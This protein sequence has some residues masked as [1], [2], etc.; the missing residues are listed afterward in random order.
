MIKEEERKIFNDFLKKNPNPGKK[1]EDY[2]IIIS[3]K[4]YYKLYDWITGDKEILISSKGISMRNAC[5]K[6]NITQEIYYDIV[7]LGLISIDDR[8]KCLCG[9]YTKFDSIY[10]GYDKYCSQECYYKY[11]IVPKNFIN[12]GNRFIKG[13]SKSEEMKKKISLGKRGKPNNR[14][15]LTAQHK[16]NI[17]KANKGRKI[18]KS[19]RKKLSLAARNRISKNPEQVIL[20]LSN[21]DIDKCKRKGKRGNYKPIK[22]D[23]EIR[24]LSTWELKFMKM[25]DLSK[26]ILK[27][28]TVES[29]PY[30]LSGK[31]HMYIPDF[32][33][34]LDTGL[35]VI[36][37]IKPKNLI[38]DPVVIA[39]RI[40]AKKYCRK[41]GYKYITLT[42]IEL[43]KRIKGSFNIYDYVV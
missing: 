11:R 25:C 22:S 16:E 26:D 38:N 9:N 33:L 39:K 27:I 36:I 34:K 8:P 42:E 3:K 32:K 7:V 17:S 23:K 29:I 40:T 37:E 35:T 15:H 31:D 41:M 2:K 20:N 12:S 13:E 24:Y 4:I 19:W 21:K 18:T 43:F 30:V 5:I 6:Y 10:S 1:Y 28:D 14:P